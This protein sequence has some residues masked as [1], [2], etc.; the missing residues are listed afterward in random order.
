MFLFRHA[1]DT[2]LPAG[3]V[4]DSDPVESSARISWFDPARQ[5]WFQTYYDTPATLRA[6]Y[7]LAFERGLAGVGMFTL[8]Y[9]GGLGGY[10]ELV[11]DVFSLPV[12][13]VA[14]VNPA[15]TEVLA[16]TV[17]ATL[18]DGLAA[19]SGVRLSNDGVTWSDWLDPAAA[20]QM[21]WLLADGADG[22]R[23]VYV[24]SGDVSGALSAPFEAPVV[25]DRTAPVIDSLALLPDG[26]GG[27]TATF[28]ITDLGGL[29]TL[30]Q[31]W[32]V[33]GGEWG[34]WTALD[35]AATSSVVTAARGTDHGQRRHRGRATRHRQGRPRDGRPRQPAARCHRRAPPHPASRQHAPTSPAPGSS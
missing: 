7:L 9:D 11:G 1:L 16:V 28:A 14:T 12:V 18:Y 4:L 26:A 35:P 27:W 25:L 20:G 34:E 19:T 3:A 2:P 5:S 29:A 21:A 10:P 31:R 24:Q 8:G 22:P 32:R 17:A 23:V 33:P 13:A 30:E 15:A 6:K